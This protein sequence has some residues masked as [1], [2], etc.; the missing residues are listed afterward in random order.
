MNPNQGQT[1]QNPAQYAQ[2]YAGYM[3]TTAQNNYYAAS[4]YPGYSG[5]ASYPYYGM[6]AIPSQ[7]P[8]MPAIPAPNSQVNINST[9]VS[10]SKFTIRYH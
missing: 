6:T 5:Y 1:G 2:Q 3:A 4:G 10:S 7:V 9:Y 8:P